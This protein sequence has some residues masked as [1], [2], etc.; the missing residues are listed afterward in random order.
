V[1]RPTGS[2]SRSWAGGRQQRRRVAHSD[3]TGI[4]FIRIVSG[5]NHV[6]PSTGGGLPGRRME[7]G[8]HSS[9]ARLARKPTRN[10]DPMVI[11]RYS[12]KPRRVKA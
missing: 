2:G 1:V 11:T 6:L 8:S 4:R 5:T 9:R 12:Y 10:G 3:G 7:R